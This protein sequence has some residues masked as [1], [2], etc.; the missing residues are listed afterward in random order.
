MKKRYFVRLNAVGYTDFA[1]LAKSKRE[2]LEI[3]DSH[4]YLATCHCDGFQ[5]TEVSKEPF[6][7]FSEE[8]TIELSDDDPVIEL[9]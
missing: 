7:A 9:A 6:S 2:A 1:V 3:A 4:N 5:A 8:E